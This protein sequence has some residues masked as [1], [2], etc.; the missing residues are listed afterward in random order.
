MVISMCVESSDVKFTLSKFIK[1]FLKIAVTGII[2][3]KMNKNKF[4]IQ[5]S[6][7]MKT[8]HTQ[9]KI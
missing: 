1:R 5:D 7:G 2:W 6:S 3:S 9:V 8:I 4:T